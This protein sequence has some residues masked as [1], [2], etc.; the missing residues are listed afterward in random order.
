MNQYEWKRDSQNNIIYDYSDEELS[1]R[2]EY[3]KQIDKYSELSYKDMMQVLSPGKSIIAFGPGKGKTT[4]LRQFLCRPEV[5]S[6][7]ALVAL[8]RIDYIDQLVYDLCAMVP[9]YKNY[10]TAYHSKSDSLSEV[11]KDLDFLKEFK[12]VVTTHQRLLLDDSSVLLNLNDTYEKLGGGSSR[13]YVIIDENPNYLSKIRFSNEG[14]ASLL[15]HCKYLAKDLECYI[16]ELD[17]RLVVESIYKDMI[18]D[19]S[20]YNVVAS[21]YE[22]L[23]GHKSY[24][25]MS[26]RSL[27]SSRFL[28]KLSVV[29]KT[30]L[31]NY[32]RGVPT[33]V[34]NI[35]YHLGLL[36]SEYVVILDGTGDII[37]KS[38]SMWKVLAK[39]PRKLSLSNLKILPNTNLSRRP[40]SCCDYREFVDAIT[41]V[42]RTHDKVLV[43]TWKDLKDFC[44]YNQEYELDG[45]T[46]ET[47]VDDSG[48]I[49]NAVKEV[50][51]RELIITSDF[52]EYLRSQLPY[53]VNQKVEIISYLSGKERVTSE[54]SDSDAI[55]FLGKFF[56]PNHEVSKLNTL[57]ESSETTKDY[58]SSIL[59]QSVYRTQA[60]HCKPISI[61][62]TSDWTQSYV[63]ELL[64]YFE[65]S[66]DSLEVASMFTK[67]YLL[68]TL[69]RNKRTS[70]YVDMILSKSSELLMNGKAEYAVPEGERTSDYKNA[71]KN[72]VSNSEYLSYTNVP[73]TKYFIIELLL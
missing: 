60:R 22:G 16:E 35:Y 44:T 71:I 43:V 58:T 56:L 21:P 10:I 69:K 59:V 49:V 66:E 63:T 19:E 4:A 13:K 47:L 2:R 46:E 51:N 9:R 18:E 45:S 17:Y 68:T 39:T 61:Y 50:T 72:Y 41:K 26:S 3:L 37:N 15:L 65:L 14:V 40:D 33:D 34:N 6:S 24:G 12:I 36:E 64:Q 5:L 67:K 52:V 31:E 32:R 8:H 29:T 55:V 23:I 25:S 62:F 11:R 53:D 73:N 54:Y 38:S 28:H 70:R 48:V 30:F 57:K 20:M 42:A 27:E 1:R 7:G